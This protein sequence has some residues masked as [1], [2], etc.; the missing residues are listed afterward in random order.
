MTLASLGKAFAALQAEFKSLLSVVNGLTVYPQDLAATNARVDAMAKELTGLA[1]GRIV[2]PDIERGMV[3]R[4]ELDAVMRRVAELER[5][6]VSVGVPMPPVH[7]ALRPVP[8]VP[9]DWATAPSTRMKLDA[10]MIQ[11]QQLMRERD[12][13]VAEAKRQRKRADSLCEE[14]DGLGKD[15]HDARN[16]IDAMRRVMDASRNNLGG[17][18]PAG[19]VKDK[20]QWDNPPWANSNHAGSQNLAPQSERA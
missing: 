15:L 12:V 2:A 8:V 3:G 18:I 1:I 14:R 7:Q 11:N 9:D 17:T 19:N 10:A 16:T 6:L 5:R 4:S 13:W 20:P